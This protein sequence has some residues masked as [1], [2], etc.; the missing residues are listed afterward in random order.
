MRKENILLA[1]GKFNYPDLGS[2]LTI[3]EFYLQKFALSRH[4]VRSMGKSLEWV[5]ASQSLLQDPSSGGPFGSQRGSLWGHHLSL[6][7]KF[8][9]HSLTAKSPDAFNVRPELQT[10]HKGSQSHNKLIP[11]PGLLTSGPYIKNQCVRASL[12]PSHL[13]PLVLL[14]LCVLKYSLHVSYICYIILEHTLPPSH[15]CISTENQNNGTH[16]RHH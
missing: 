11:S 6:C 16:Y 12:H 2:T 1:F 5:L 10:A 15:A 4:P 9:S 14:S 13:P 7:E 8:P 3:V